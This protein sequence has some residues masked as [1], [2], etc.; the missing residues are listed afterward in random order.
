VSEISV[1]GSLISVV[2][3]DEGSS[4]NEPVDAA[5]GEALCVQG[6]GSAFEEQLE[7]GSPLTVWMGAIGTG[8]GQ[9]PHD[10]FL[11]TEIGVGAVHAD[12]LEVLAGQIL[13]GLR[14][15]REVEGQFEVLAELVQDDP[16]YRVAG[17]VLKSLQG[18]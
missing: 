8:G 13:P 17:D 11:G 18:L 16:R 15:G 2:E 5:G 14:L 4:Q 10:S 6:E 3:A 7:P 12:S 9:G 1:E